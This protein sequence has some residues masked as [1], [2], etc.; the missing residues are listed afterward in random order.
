MRLKKLLF[1][2][3]L[4]PFLLSGCQEEPTGPASEGPDM[5]FDVPGFM[6]AQIAQ[7][8]TNKPQVRKT[9]AIRHEKPEI[10]LQTPQNWTEELQYFTETDLNKKAL[11]GAYQIS[12]THSGPHKITRYT[13]KP[14]NSASVSELEVRAD[15][16][17]NVFSLKILTEQKNMLVYTRESREF[18]LNAARKLKSYRISGVQKVMLSD[19]L[20]Y[21]TLSEA[22]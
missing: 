8:Q 1:T 7:L 6:K 4:L 9:V 12:E 17:R 16:A 20:R 13:L 18:S 14:G 15:A 2:A 10:R 3:A 5:Y 22:L 21:E 11:R 19:S